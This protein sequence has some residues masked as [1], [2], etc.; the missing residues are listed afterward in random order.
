MAM[1]FRSVAVVGCVAAALAVTVGAE[2]SA[3]AQQPAAKLQPKAAPSDARGLDGVWYVDNPARL[4]RD[5]TVHHG[6]ATEPGALPDSRVLWPLDG[7][8]PPFTPWG[9]EHFNTRFQAA[10]NNQPIADP[11]TDCIPHGTPRVQVPNYPF[12]IVVTPQI[13]G[14]LYEVAHDVRLV[15][16]NQPLPQHLPITQMGTSVGHWDGNTLVVHTEGLSDSAILDQM[17]TPHSDQLKLTERIRTINGG[18]QLED[19]ITFDDPVAFRSPWTTRQVFNKRPDMRLM[20]YVCEE[21]NR[22]VSNAN[23]QTTVK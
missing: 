5:W 23:G 7:S 1:R 20:E 16:M 22:N 6:S 11:S 19:L 21:N 9:L 18:R 12:Q 8:P 14:M 15:Y 13:V 4:D 10:L 2:S 3:L 17:G